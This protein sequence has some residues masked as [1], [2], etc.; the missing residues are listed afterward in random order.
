MQILL[1]HPYQHLYN[2]TSLQLHRYQPLYNNHNQQFYIISSPNLLHIK[3]LPRQYTISLHLSQCSAFPT[4][5]PLQPPLIP[6]SLPSIS[7]FGQRCDVV[8]SCKHDSTT[9]QR[10]WFVGN[11]YI[12]SRF[13]FS[14]HSHYY[15][16]IGF[17][18]AFH[19]PSLPLS[20]VL[21]RS[22]LILDHF[23]TIFLL[24]QSYFIDFGLFFVDFCSKITQ[25]LLKSCINFG[26]TPQTCLILCKY[27][28]FH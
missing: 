2:P 25:I 24:F 1:I 17:I 16:C 27:V 28:D 19:A 21:G 9:S 8:E 18:N 20:L 15:S 22:P 7:D 23:G 13:P 12:S 5:H 3:L 6:P 26:Q 10:N 11:S 14:L 4:S